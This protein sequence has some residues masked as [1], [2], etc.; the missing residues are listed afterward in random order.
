MRPF[1]NHRA[2][3]PP[4]DPSDGS[5]S[6]SLSLSPSPSSVP[7]ALPFPGF[8][9]KPTNPILSRTSARYIYIYIYC[10]ASAVAIVSFYLNAPRRVPTGALTALNAARDVDMRFNLPVPAVPSRRA[11]PRKKNLLMS[12]CRASEIGIKGAPCWKLGRARGGATCA[13]LSRL[14]PSAFIP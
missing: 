12:D 8:A 2:F 6:F 4:F 9:L 10:P 13:V 7:P 1:S 14:P 11:A 5:R 3:C